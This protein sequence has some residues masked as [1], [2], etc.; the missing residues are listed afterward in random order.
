MSDDKTPQTELVILGSGCSSGTPRAGND[1]GACDPHNPKNIRYRPSVWVKSNTTSIVVDTGPDFRFQC[2]REE[3][4]QIDA[5]L[6]THR[7]SDHVNGM[8]DLRPYFWRRGRTRLPLYMDKPTYQELIQRFSYIFESTDPLYPAIGEAKIWD[9]SDFD[10]THKIG[11]IEFQIFAQDHS[12]M[13]SCGFRFG[14]VAYSTDM[15]DIVSER[16]VEILR[17]V[18]VWIIDGANWK[19]NDDQ[20]MCHPTLGQLKRLQDKICPQKIFLTHLKNDSDYQSLKEVLP[21]GMEPA[22]DGLS[23]S[24]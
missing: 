3:I 10:Q 19:W 14:R 6:Y 12:T 8:D 22:Y 15:I 21:E 4:D 24:C 20:M 13:N 11:D 17:D 23:F 5:V 18:P 2:N 16:A 7:H 9:S 1:W